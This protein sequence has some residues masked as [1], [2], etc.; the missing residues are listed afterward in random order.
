[1]RFKR[2]QNG[3]T[4]QSGMVVFVRNC[5]EWLIRVVNGD[6]TFYDVEKEPWVTQVESQTE[7]IVAEL[8]AVL[9]TGVPA[10]QKLS[11]DPQVQQGDSWKTFVLYAYGQP[12]LSNQQ[13][14]PNTVD[15]LSHIPGMKTAWFSILEPQTSLPPHE[16]PYNGMLRYHLGLIIPSEG[17]EFCGIRVGK[18]TRNWKKG[19]SLLFDDTHDH[20]AWNK[21]NEKRVV[22]FVDMIRPLPIPFS[23]LNKL[24]INIAGKS[25]F[26]KQIIERAEAN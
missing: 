8:N 23:W 1:M 16:G 11:D 18:D 3:G 4:T 7:S 15:A 24:V 22:L 13:K 26:I 25:P 14:C 21:T 10:W 9:E 2:Y 12:V 20:E 6:K 19:K 17:S 5:V